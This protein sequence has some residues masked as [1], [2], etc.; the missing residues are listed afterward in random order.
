MVLKS[1]TACLNWNYCNCYNFT[2]LLK[3]CRQVQYLQSAWICY[4]HCLNNSA[5]YGSIWNR[6]E[7]HHNF[8]NPI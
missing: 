7:N 2:K 3:F 1:E 6:Q 4:L 5:C 8:D